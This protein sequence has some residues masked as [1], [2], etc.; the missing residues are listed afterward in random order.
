ME[1]KNQMARI[2]V[3]YIGN[4]RIVWINRRAETKVRHRC[5]SH[6]GALKH[7]PKYNEKPYLTIIFF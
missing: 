7:G 2:R 6:L 5:C 1:T 3:I 4:L